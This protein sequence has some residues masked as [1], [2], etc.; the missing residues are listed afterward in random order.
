MAENNEYLGSEDRQRYTLV[1]L[2]CQRHKD[3][4]N[5]AQRCGL[6]LR[7]QRAGRRNRALQRKPVRLLRAAGLLHIRRLGQ[8][9]VDIRQYG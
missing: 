3:I 5:H 9:A 8:G 1:Q 7:L 2:R 4:D 6:L